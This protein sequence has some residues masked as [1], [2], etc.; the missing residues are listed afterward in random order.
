MHTQP[1]PESAGTFTKTTYSDK[2]HNATCDGRVRIEQWESSC[3]GYE[4]D[5]LTC[6][7]CGHVW[8]VEGPDS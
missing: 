3:G 8:W 6:E 4:D 1:M 7:K 2:P 5:K